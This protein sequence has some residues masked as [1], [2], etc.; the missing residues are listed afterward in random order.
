MPTPTPEL[1]QLNIR[2][3]AELNDALEQAADKERRSKNAQAVV[4]LEEWLKTKSE[5]SPTPRPSRKP[6]KATI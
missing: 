5:P 1:I 2:V 6:V 4:I 3:P